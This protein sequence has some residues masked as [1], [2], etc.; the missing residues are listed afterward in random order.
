[1]Y[2]R[3]QYTTYVYVWFKVTTVYPCGVRVSVGLGEILETRIR[4]PRGLVDPPLR[5]ALRRL[6]DRP[7]LQY[8]CLLVCVPRLDLSWLKRRQVHRINIRRIYAMY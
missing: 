6:R 8:L 2:H 3:I 7:E 5:R 4:Q 1:M